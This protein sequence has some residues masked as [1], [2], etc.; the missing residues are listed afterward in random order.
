MNTKLIH[1]IKIDENIT[2]KLAIPE[3]LTAIE[4]KGLFLK[5]DKLFKLSDATHLIPIEPTT[6]A[7]NINNNK[8]TTYSKRWTEQE[9]EF[10]KNNVL[11]MD[12]QQ[13]SDK[14]NR[15]LREVQNKIYQ[16]GIKIPRLKKEGGSRYKARFTPE[17]REEIY[18]EWKVNPDLH[19]LAQKFKLE[20]EKVKGVVMYCRMIESRKK[21]MEEQ[22]NV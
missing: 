8:R 13:I 20:Y 12:K 5:A 15:N 21:K 14:L 3:E 18:N 2:V 11:T 1:S 17:Q 9:T 10:L 16:L 4:L 19:F 6:T 22:N 7:Q